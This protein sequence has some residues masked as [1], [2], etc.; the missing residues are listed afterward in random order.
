M[1]AT[2]NVGFRSEG[3]LLNPSVIFRDLARGEIEEAVVPID[4]L[5]AARRFWVINS[6]QE[7]REAVLLES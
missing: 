6:V 1:T 5:R 4:E 3:P 7:R 2:R